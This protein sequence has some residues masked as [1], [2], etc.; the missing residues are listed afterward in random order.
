[1]TSRRTHAAVEARRERIREAVSAQGHV[2]SDELAASLGVSVMTIL[3]DLDTLAAD[4]WLRRTPGGATVERSALFE[5]NVRT[6]MRENETAKAAIGRAAAELVRPGD[7]VLLDD[8]TTALASVEALMSLRPL[9]VVSNFRRVLDALVGVSQIDLVSLGGRYNPPYDSF[10]GLA[11]VEALRGLHVDIAFFSALAVTAGQCYH[12]VPES[13]AVKRAMIAAADRSVLL[14]D[15]SKF[16]RTALYR[17]CG[18]DEVDTV[19]LDD[20]VAPEHLRAIEEIAAD[21]IVAPSSPTASGR[22][23][24]VVE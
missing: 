8:S 1:M 15:H 13:V 10:G 12:P 18:L 17:L 24:A 19:I 5:L 23:A 20:G 11:T 22:G 16:E 6:R 9:T 14:V 2:R 21:V 3:R 4:G 7:A